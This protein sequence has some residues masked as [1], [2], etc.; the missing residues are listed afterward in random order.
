[1]KAPNVERT[2]AMAVDDVIPRAATQQQAE[3]ADHVDAR[4]GKRYGEPAK[5]FASALSDARFIP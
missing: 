1:M 5:G 4:D 3:F 2:L